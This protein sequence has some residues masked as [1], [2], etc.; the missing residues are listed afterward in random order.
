MITSRFVTILR[1]P[2]FSLLGKEAK[3][4]SLNYQVIDAIRKL[5][6]AMWRDN[7]EAAA[8]VFEFLYQFTSL[9]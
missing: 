6:G 5:C 8:A 2:V 7:S 3:C 9:I 1:E 4:L